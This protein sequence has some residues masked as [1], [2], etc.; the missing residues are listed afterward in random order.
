MD[1]DTPPSSNL[2]NLN[3][4]KP[5]PVAPPATDANTDAQPEKE[6][7]TKRILCFGD[8][9]TKGGY[10]GDRIHHPYT[11]KLRQLFK[12]NK[13]GVNYHIINHG[14]TG[15]CVSRKMKRR[16]SDDLDNLPPLDLVVLFA[17]T[18]DLMHEDCAHDVELFQHI[19]TLHEMVHDKGYKSIVVTIPESQVYANGTARMTLAEYKD[20]IEDVNQKLRMYAATEKLP[21]CDLA[22]EFPRYAMPG[23]TRNLADMWDDSVHPN[24]LGYDRIGQILYSDIYKYV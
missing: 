21:I 17:G 1:K 5:K 19:R 16:L 18:E 7:P 14:M 11:V 15:D 23:D 22:D 3:A 6:V 9:M 8:S 13:K 2:E 12:E 10:A 20:A 4:P 24:A